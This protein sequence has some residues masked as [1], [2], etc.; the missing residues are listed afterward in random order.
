V[1]QSTQ[2][3]LSVVISAENV[4]SRCIE[5]IVAGTHLV[6]PSSST[7][8]SICCPSYGHSQ[9]AGGGC[10]GPLFSAI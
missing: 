2:Q 7:S 6:S 4:E 5:V 9:F 10:D 1:N 3:S 8:T